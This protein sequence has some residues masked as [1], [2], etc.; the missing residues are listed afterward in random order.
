MRVTTRKN[1]LVASSGRVQKRGSDASRARGLG[2]RYT[3]E[4]AREAGRLGAAKLAARRAAE[5]ERVVIDLLMSWQPALVLIAAWQTDRRDLW[6][7][8]L[9][10][11]EEGRP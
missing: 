1:G 10:K 2:H 8:V 3:A 7:R 6:E 4:Q 11:R 5:A 9:E